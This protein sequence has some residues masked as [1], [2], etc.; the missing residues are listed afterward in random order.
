V[1]LRRILGGGV[2]GRRRMI[3]MSG[4]LLDLG[5]REEMG[6]IVRVVD[7]EHMSGA[8]NGLHIELK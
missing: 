3:G 7:S 4:D 8:D 1:L 6:G 5:G 2:E